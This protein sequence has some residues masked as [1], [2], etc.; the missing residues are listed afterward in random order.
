MSL[1]RCVNLAE[2]RRAGAHLLEDWGTRTL[3]NGMALSITGD[4]GPFTGAAKA[5]LAGLTVLH[6]Q[7]RSGGAHGRVRRAC[8]RPD[9]LPPMTTLTEAGVRV[10]C[11]TNGSGVPHLVVP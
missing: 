10:A 4:L 9:A 3:P 5:A 6:A 2:N 1:D 7:R 11:L 8:P